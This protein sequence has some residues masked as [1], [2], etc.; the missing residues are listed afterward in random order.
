MLR[1]EY[2]IAQLSALQPRDD[3]VFVAFSTHSRLEE[4]GLGYGQNDGAN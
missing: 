3:Q 1:V 2:I 4:H